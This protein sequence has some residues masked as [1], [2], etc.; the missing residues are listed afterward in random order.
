M[1]GTDVRTTR[2]RTLPPV[3]RRSAHH[4]L[5][6]AAA[7][8][9]VLLAGTVLASLASLAG[10]AVDAGVD[11]RLAADPNTNVQTTA[12]YAQGG[13]DSGDAD[14]QAA[15]AR[16]FQGIPAQ[17][18]IALS[19]L[20]PLSVAPGG[21]K[22]LG[23]P[24]LL[25][26]SA[27]QGVAAHAGLVE[28]VWP[29]GAGDASRADFRS[30]PGYRPGTDA[31]GAGG[32][33]PAAVPTVLAQQYGLHVGEQLPL[34]DAY[35]HPVAILV[36]GI[37]RGGGADPGYWPAVADDADGGGALAAGP[38]V[39]SPRAMVANAAFNQGIWALWYS[40]PN[41]ARLDGGQVSLLNQRV[42]DYTQSDIA[43]SVFHG[44]RTQLLS[45]SASSGIPGI[46]GSLDTTTV[47]ARSALYLPAALLA[48]LA[49]VSLVLTARQLVE[50]RQS[51]LV[52]QQTRGAG[53][54]RLVG[55][56][57]AEWALLVLPAAAVSPFL[58]GPL[59]HGL[60][61]AGLLSGP[62]PLDTVG[63]G[64]WLAVGATVLIH[65]LAT[66]VPVLRTVSGRDPLARLRLRGARA[67]AAQRIGAD[68]ALLLVAVL[69]YLELL[70]YHSTVV[71]TSVDPVLLLVPVAC[72]VAAALLLLRLLPLASR[73]LDAFGRRRRGLVLPLAGWQLSRRASR[74]A[75]PVLLM[76]LA[77]A[78]G[79]LSTTAIACLD[80]LA[81]DQA[82]FTVGADVAV[83]T[84]SASSYPQTVLARDYLRLPGVTAV[85]PVTDTPVSTASGDAVE[86]VGIDTTRVGAA[87]P[88]PPLPTLRG[89]L[90][91]PGFAARVAGL[92][93]GGHGYGLPIAGDAP[94]LSLTESLTESDPA[95]PP[96]TIVVTV[97]D[98]E[99]LT[100]SLS[101]VL[102]AA[103][104]ATRT[105]ALSYGSTGG[106]RLVA[107]LRIVGVQL[108][109]VFDIPPGGAPQP[110]S[111]YR[112]V[113][114]RFSAGGAAASVLPAHVS[115]TDRTPVLQG[116]LPFQPCGP[117]GRIS[118]NVTQICS[119]G[120][121]RA[122]GPALE[123]VFTTGAPG[124][125]AGSEAVELS[126][127]Q[128]AEQL[129]VPALA[130]DAFLHAENLQVGAAL[131]LQLDQD[132]G[133]Q[134]L[135]VGVVH[136]IPGVGSAGGHLLVD[137]RALAAASD[138]A[139]AVVQPATDWWL[140][141]GAPAATAAAIAGAPGLGSA[142]TTPQV[143]AQ[144][145]ADPFR[146]GMRTVL[147]LCRL[148]APAFAVIGF[149][150]HAVVSTRERRREFALLRAMGTPSRRLATL[151]R[152]EQ[153]AVVL[154]AVVPG[155]LIGVGLAAAILPR[156][157]VDDDG[158]PPFPSMLVRVDW[159]TVG[160]TAVATAGVIWLV[161]IS[162]SRLLARVDL[163][164]T[165]RAGED[166]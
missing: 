163:V 85:T 81:R 13:F 71:G 12:T 59:L 70:H 32:P 89:D 160:A 18:S 34:V 106:G 20:S 109:P 60:H 155:A 119:V 118:G 47:V 30:L 50:H 105:V 16:V 10:S 139:G 121:G 158:S 80:G 49:L 37:Y 87:L 76:C 142:Q 98:A 62:M 36:V 157:V 150:V 152:A 44:Q 7:A 100:Q 90:A 127:E 63:A 11:V 112:L 3:V 132:H 125:I 1:A 55:G 165:L 123:A 136:D 96:P 27:A 111:T 2:A 51:E 161:V 64:A 69:G 45:V 9:I 92:A 164:R 131:P 68:L 82:A 35:G 130:D 61:A 126:A 25:H 162:M 54:G 97:E 24:T 138:Q 75:G 26:A 83:D 58:S 86:I 28:G 94:Q 144:L 103:D 38:L 143:Q 108:V 21:P 145:E 116:D 88:A 122:G 17:T 91:G 166:A 4:G 124:G 148:L 102:P 42:T 33:V 79:A 19:G 73:V 95:A 72:T 156:V 53:A 46:V 115:W 6:L 146:S 159:L 22:P 99:G 147:A 48:A 56:A 8:L 40:E 41:Y 154:F 52:L 43:T 78:V 29:P 84:G 110:A 15:L 120:G 129:A 104:G 134:V 57:A 141:S 149:T 128:P 5:V 74:N 66:L 137:Q 133:I 153:L 140:S 77:V 65:A 101:A 117:Q 113:V 39:V 151:L 93:G 135:I 67:A 107:P 114:D 23:V 31:A 14:V